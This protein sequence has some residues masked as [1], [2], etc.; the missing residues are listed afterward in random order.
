MVSESSGR[1][2]QL[3]RVSGADLRTPLG[4]SGR[5]IVVGAGGAVGESAVLH[6]CAAG[7]R[8]AA[9]M[10]R[11]HAE[12]SARLVAAGA[13]VAQLD[14]EGDARGRFDGADAVILTPILSLAVR[15]APELARAGVRRVI[16]FSSNNVAIDP[17][18]PTYVA[19]AA[20]EAELRASIP[21]AIILRPTLIYGD[22][23][24]TALARLITWAR[25]APIL[26]VPG[27]GRALQQP[28]FHDDLGRIAAVLAQSTAHEGATFALGGPE[29]VTMRV[30]FQAVV[31][32][33]GLPALVTPTPRWLLAAGLAILG[34]RF[35]LDAAQIARV[36][37]NRVAIAQTP[38]PAAFTPDTDLRSGLARLVDAMD[39]RVTIRRRAV[40]A[41]R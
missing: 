40:H 35:P 15:V 25:R 13:E 21:H 34:E 26:P 33:A 39:A 1:F 24:Q 20:A 18:A 12:A 41:L 23:R 19:L 32:A 14:L 9:A 31:R 27:S 16:A 38:L 22:P 3:E 6:L 36:E 30:L 11:A 28:V 37:Q 2:K 5:A 17:G 29:V 4:M 8:V 7:W 10:R